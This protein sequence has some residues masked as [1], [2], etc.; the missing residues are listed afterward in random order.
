MKT[1]TRNVGTPAFL[2]FV[3]ISF[4]FPVR[5][6]RSIFDLSKY[7]VQNMKSLSMLLLGVGGR[8][9]CF[10]TPSSTII[11]MNNSDVDTITS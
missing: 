9:W 5:L 1:N 4:V 7:L 10:A 8:N 11:T 6:K 2:L 3:L